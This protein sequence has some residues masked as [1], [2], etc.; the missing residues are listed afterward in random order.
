MTQSSKPRPIV[1]GALVAGLI[2]ISA[3]VTFAQEP[4]GN[5]DETCSSFGYVTTGLS[6]RTYQIEPSTGKNQMV[7]DRYT[8]RS[9]GEIATLDAFGFNTKDA[10]LYAWDHNYKRPV[11]INQSGGVDIIPV[12]GAPNTTFYAGDISLNPN[13]YYVYRPGTAYGLYYLDLDKDSGNYG[14]LYRVKGSEH[15][16][17]SISDFAFHPSDGFAYAVDID[18]DVFLSLIHI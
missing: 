3:P 17:I 9:T 6:H 11:R 7:V 12:E 4:A 15:L 18:G 13:R 1:I 5:I 2:S 8:H 16:D 10:H 14:K